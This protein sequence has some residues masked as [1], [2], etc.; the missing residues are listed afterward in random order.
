MLLIFIL[1]FTINK[2]KVTCDL[3]DLSNVNKSELAAVTSTPLPWFE[4]GELLHNSQ[5]KVKSKKNKKT[6]SEQHQNHLDTKSAKMGK[7]PAKRK[8]RL[9]ENL[10][11]KN[12]MQ[13]HDQIKWK[14][15]NKSNET[16]QKIKDTDM[17]TFNRSGQSLSLVTRLK[18]Y[19]KTQPIDGKEVIGDALTEK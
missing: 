3:V 7:Q 16:Q 18:T 9:K 14:N 5:K 10:I 17:M 8:H 2:E 4:P 19:Q 6:K 15:G 13:Q 11:N 1:V 12:K